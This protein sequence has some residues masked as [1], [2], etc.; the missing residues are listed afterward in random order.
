MNLNE[1]Q[2]FL[3]KIGLKFK[4]FIHPKQQQIVLRIFHNVP[5]ESSKFEDI[6]YDI[7]GNYL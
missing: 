4:V 2:T 7:N 5:V 1:M 6:T 3:N